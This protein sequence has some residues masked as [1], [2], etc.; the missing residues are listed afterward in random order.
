MNPQFNPQSANFIALESIQIAKPC[1][2]DW[3]AMVG[4]NRARHCRSCDK[5]VYN[6]SAMSRAQAQ[7]LILEN[8]G[9]LCIQ[10]HRRADG[11]VISSDCPVGISPVKKPSK[12]LSK[13]LGGLVAAILSIFGI[14]NSR[15]AEPA[16]RVTAGAPMVMGEAPMIMGSPAVPKIAPTPKS[17][18][19]YANR[20]RKSNLKA[21]SGHRRHR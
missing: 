18:K 9:H 7:R 13:A 8:E 20:A 14:A 16:A 4:D 6:L 1:R 5:N 17:T 2:A 10:L 21:R 11:T 3:N 19:K 15:A 12:W